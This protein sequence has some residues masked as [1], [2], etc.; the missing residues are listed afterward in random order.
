[1]SPSHRPRAGVAGSSS[2]DVYFHWAWFTTAGYHSNMSCWSLDLQECHAVA[3]EAPDRWPIKNSDARSFKMKLLITG[4]SVSFL[5]V[6]ILLLESCTRDAEK[7]A[8]QAETQRETFPVS[9]SAR[10]QRVRERWNVFQASLLQQYEPLSA[11]D[12]AGSARFATAWLHRAG[13]VPFWTMGRD[14][15]ATI[16]GLWLLAT[17]IPRAPAAS[18]VLLVQLSKVKLSKDRIED[19]E[20]AN[21]QPPLSSGVKSERRANHQRSAPPEASIVAGLQPIRFQINNA[22][23]EHPQLR[24]LAWFH[25]FPSWYAEDPL[26][27]Q[28]GLLFQQS[29]LLREQFMK[30]AEA[31]QRLHSSVEELR[32]DLQA[33][34]QQR[35]HS[36]DERFSSPD[37][38]RD[39]IEEKMALLREEVS[40]RSRSSEAEVQRLGSCLDTGQLKM[41]DNLAAKIAAVE[42]SFGSSMA[43]KAALE[44]LRQKLEKQLQEVKES[45]DSTL[46]VHEAALL[47]EI[48]RIRSDAIL[49]A[50]EWSQRV[51]KVEKASQKLM[52]NEHQQTRISAVGLATELNELREALSKESQSYQ[53]ST[54][55]VQRWV[56]ETMALKQALQDEDRANRAPH[57]SDW[58]L[59]TSER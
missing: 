15:G 52:A 32:D 18:D 16:F 36:E 30:F 6:V 53:E 49:E 19:T 29:E 34:H 2:D 55:S 48:C 17:L 43:T 13:D 31:L 12:V 1:M 39:Q 3:L 59:G 57:R 41:A 42:D 4:F 58:L 25:E 47:E 40:M 9:L 8:D 21:V 46:R 45:G 54:T 5:S 24:F 7:E 11:R 38:V 28:Q 37:D 22:E 35:L 44:D 14:F 51:A 50:E 20:A 27:R 33:E 26:V 23:R 10:V 56:S